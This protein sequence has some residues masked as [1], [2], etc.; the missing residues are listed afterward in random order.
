MEKPQVVIQYE[1][2]E[3]EVQKDQVVV[4]TN[5]EEVDHNEY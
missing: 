3:I 1:T 2:E 4:I 5:I